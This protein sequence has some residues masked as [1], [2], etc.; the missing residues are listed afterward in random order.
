[1]LGYNDDILVSSYLDC[2]AT[3]SLHHII[4][5]MLSTGTEIYS[6]SRTSDVHQVGH[7]FGGKNL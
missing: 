3:I 1:M 6:R 2:S 4:A 7:Y 5:V